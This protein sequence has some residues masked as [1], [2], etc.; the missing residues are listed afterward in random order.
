MRFDRS[1]STVRPKLL[2]YRRLNRTEICAQDLHYQ[3]CK[4][5]G[6]LCLNNTDQQRHVTEEFVTVVSARDTSKKK[7]N[8]EGYLEFVVVCD[9]GRGGGGNSSNTV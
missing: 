3:S 1:S 5:Q 9:G 8:Y 4:K 6:N 7:K 2:V